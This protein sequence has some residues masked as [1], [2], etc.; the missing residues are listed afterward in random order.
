ME[1]RFSLQRQEVFAENRINALS[2]SVKEL[3]QEY[4]EIISLTFFGSLSKGQSKIESDID[5]ALYI[6]A[7][8][9]SEREKSEG[10]KDDDVIDI[11]QEK[12]TLVQ[13]LKTQ[14]ISLKIFLRSDLYEKYN[15]L[16][17]DKV[18]QKDHTLSSEQVEHLRALPMS[19]K[20]LI[21]LMDKIVKSMRLLKDF[22]QKVLDAHSGEKNMEEF[23]KTAK[24][25]GGE[26]DTILETPTLLLGTMFHLD[27]GGG[28]RKY[29]KLLINKLL[30]SGEEGE[31]IWKDIIGYVEKWEQKTTY[32]E[33]PTSIHY[34]R[35]LSEAKEIYC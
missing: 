2:E 26:P 31:K 15:K 35:T 17:Q 9:V 16:I 34:P 21:D 14:K 23:L 11:R 3:Q 19:E 32:K 25:I 8:L 13:G 12:E 6:D 7:D 29:R 18:L 27:V 5:G 20:V 28:I 33:L 24:A 1:K 4:P 10:K 30:E 22:N